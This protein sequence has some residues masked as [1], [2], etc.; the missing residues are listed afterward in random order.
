MRS[1]RSDR[2]SEVEEPGSPSAAAQPASAAAQPASATQPVLSARGLNKSFSGVHVLRDVDFVLG[3]GTIHTIVGE[4]GAGKSTLIKS[5]TAV[6]Q[7]DSGSIELA[8][9]PVSFN[10]PS[11]AQDAGISTVYQEVNLVPLLSVARNIFLG[12][13]PRTRLGLIDLKALNSR[14]AEVV[15]DLGIDVDVTAELG[16]LGLGVQ[17]MIALARAVTT[18]AKVIIMDEPTSSLERR[19]VDVLF[20]V[21]RRLRDQ[22]AGIVFVSHRLDELWE[23]CDEVT[24]LRD[25]EVVH[26]GA[27]ADLD[28]RSLISAML[29]RDIAEHGVT[30]FA[31]DSPSSADDSPAAEVVLEAI[32]LNAPG[33]LHDVDVEVRA[34]EIIGLAGLLGSGR[35]ETVKAIYGA[36][37][38]SAGSIAVKGA[39][40]RRQSVPAALK[41]GIALLS[42]DRK[43]EGIVPELSVRDNIVLGILPRVSTGGVLSRK[44]IDELVDTYIDRLG[45]KVASPRQLVSELSG[46]NQQKV[47]I[48]RWLATQPSVFLL[49]EPTRGIDVGAKQEVQALIDELADRGMA[50]VLISSET[51][52]LVA[53]SE[54][55]IVLRDG[56]ISEILTGDEVDNTR[57][58]QSLVSGGQE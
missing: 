9:T 30:S 13:E 20:G 58:L 50:V 49:D 36:L 34:G 3:S 44:K 11:Q 16:A 57:L 4:N 26:T 48:A 35:S 29:G 12:R 39:P 22:G 55:V 52:E 38:T 51:E 54:S 41:A 25:G 2:H 56:E 46:G 7:A 42:E 1:S 33:R 18:E 40:I 53:G 43:S 17:Q 8:G 15:A 10:H 6:Y 45:I 28:R 14:A 23:L 27:M 32:G 19:E 21:A 37:D 24:I 31:E 5:L 47:L